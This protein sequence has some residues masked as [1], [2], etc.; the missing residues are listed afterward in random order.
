MNFFRLEI[1]SLGV[2][3]H[4]RVA[5]P[6]PALCS[7]VKSSAIYLDVQHAQFEFVHKD[8]RFVENYIPGKTVSFISDGNFYVYDSY[9]L[10]IRH[11][12][13]PSITPSLVNVEAPM[14]THD[15]YSLINLFPGNIDGH[16][17]LSGILEAISQT[18]LIRVKLYTFLGG[19][20]QA[21]T[22]ADLSYIQNTVSKTFKN[23]FFSNDF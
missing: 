7:L 9:T 10:T 6:I 3:I 17:D 5:C 23:T 15:F 14:F 13:P 18:R 16:D 22:Q 19:T 21:N 2:S 12:Y 1:K 20:P 11:N 4:K 8:V